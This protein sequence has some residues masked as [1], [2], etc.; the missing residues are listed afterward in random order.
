[1]EKL[2]RDENSVRRVLPTAKERKTLKQSTGATPKVSLI[3]SERASDEAV[4]SS[5]NRVK[6]L[7]ETTERFAK[8]EKRVSSTL[9]HSLAHRFKAVTLMVIY[10]RKNPLKFGKFELKFKTG[11]CV[12]C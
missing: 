1:M 5:I 6:F 7:L 12:C 3:E 10:T 11:C 2:S 8:C 4:R 9:V